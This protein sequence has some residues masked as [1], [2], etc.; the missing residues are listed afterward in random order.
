MTATRRTETDSNA[1]RRPDQ[2][3]RR[4]TAVEKAYKE[5]SV[6]TG[7]ASA[8]TT[9]TD[10]TDYIVATSS[11]TPTYTIPSAADHDGRVIEVINNAASGSG[12]TITIDSVVCNE[13]ERTVLRSN[14]TNWVKLYAVTLV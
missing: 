14:G 8:D 1:S 11:A 3:S 4:E 13:D 12:F 10:V 2:L 7:H 6:T 5:T 9:Y